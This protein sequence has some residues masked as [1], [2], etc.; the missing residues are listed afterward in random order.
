MH[1]WFR[2]CALIALTAF[3]Q[4]THVE[5][6]TGDQVP[7]SKHQIKPTVAQVVQHSLDQQGKRLDQAAAQLTALLDAQSKQLEA[8]GKQIEALTQMAELQGKQIE[9]LNTELN[10]LNAALLSKNAPGIAEPAPRPVVQPQPSSG[11]PTA[12]ASS[13]VSVPAVKA[14]PV[15][16][17]TGVA[18]DGSPTHIVKRGENLTSIARQHGTTVSELLQIN[19]IED[20]RKLQVGQTLILPK[21]AVIPPQTPP[22]PT[23][24]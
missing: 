18:P 6:Q 17:A 20:E 16:P 23:P 10:R 5:G 13:P 4:S 2:F 12:A 19:K 14:E 11:V 7:V 8:Q 22:Q 24:P 15:A 1:R 21:S 3:A 9:T